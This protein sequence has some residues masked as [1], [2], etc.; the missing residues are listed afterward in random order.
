[1]DDQRNLT[2]EG[3]TRAI[4]KGCPW[5]ASLH[6][7]TELVGYIDRELIGRPWVAP[8]LDCLIVKPLG[9]LSS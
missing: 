1:M 2:V 7:Y 8:T 4:E 5:S 9:M 6:G 3:C